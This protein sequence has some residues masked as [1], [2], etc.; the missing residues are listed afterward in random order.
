MI[1]ITSALSRATTS[2]P[3]TWS[4]PTAAAR[5]NSAR[6]PLQVRSILPD[7]HDGQLNPYHAAA[8]SRSS[9]ATGSFLGLLALLW[10]GGIAAFVISFGRRRWSPQPVAVDAANPRFAERMRPLVEAAAAGNLSADGQADWNVCSWATGAKNLTCPRPAHGRGPGAAQGTPRGRRLAARA[11][12]LAAP[13][14]RNS[15]RRKSMP[16]LEPYRAAVPPAATAEPT[17]EARMSFHHPQWLWLLALPVL[18]GFWQW[19][20]R[21]PSAW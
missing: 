5:T 4:G 18:W 10:V 1:S 17:E 9:A 8:V 13:S 16:L 21:G 2:W 11:G 3:I 14:R 19:V 6:I 7:D 20:R 12:T 15:A